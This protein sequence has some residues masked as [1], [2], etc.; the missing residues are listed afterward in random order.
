MPRSAKIAS[1]ILLGCVIVF[2]AL[3]FNNRNDTSRFQSTDDAYVRVD[4]TM[5]APRISGQIRDVMAEENQAVRA[6]QLLAAIDDREFVI[7]VANAEAALASVRAT[8]ES[9]SRQM[10][11][12]ADVIAQARAV[13]EADKATLELGRQEYTRYRNLASDGSGSKQNLQQATAAYKIAQANLNRDTAKSESE[14]RKRDILQAELRKA[15]ALVEQATAALNLAKLNLSHCRIH[16]P[17]DG[18]VS[19]K[20]V[21]LGAYIRTGDTL[22]AIVPLQDIYIDAYFRET[23]LANIRPGQPVGIIADAF[24]GRTFAGTVASLGPA[25][26]AS[27][28]PIAPHSTSS[29]FTK[30]VQR[31]PVRI[32][33]TDEDK[34]ILKVGMSVI[35][36]VDTGSR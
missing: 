28:S 18:T 9:L 2:S 4:S 27:F 31:L 20:R 30:I 33:I 19:Q 14:V 6:G 23:Q 24:P 25:S 3:F 35:P 8:Y 17:I 15:T 21:R 32:A 36:T 16:S 1:V 34:N 5:V 26:N 10:E 22:L 12:Q 29:N 7:Q 13:V 11:Q